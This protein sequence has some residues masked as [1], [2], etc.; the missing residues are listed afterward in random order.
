MSPQVVHGR[1]GDVRI[2]AHRHRSGLPT[3]AAVRA[4]RVVVRDARPARA[5]APRP[6][7]LRKRYHAR[8][9]AG[10]ARAATPRVRGI[11]T[12]DRAQKR[13]EEPFRE[14]LAPVRAETAVRTATVHRVEAPPD[15]H[16]D[17][18]GGHLPLLQPRPLE[19]EHLL[20]DRGRH[21]RARQHL[22]RMDGVLGLLLEHFHE[23]DAVRGD[24]QQRRDV[25]QVDLPR[26][27]LDRVRPEQRPAG[28]AFDAPRH[29]VRDG[30]DDDGDEQP[31]VS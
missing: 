27:R 3:K 12:H 13:P 17:G 24:A 15:A 21:D 4:V 31:Y 23:D 18:A 1:H 7:Q 25:V 19:L 8:G 6:A 16:R 28:L 20:R 2:G 29:F 26:P 9:T 22:V 10:P 11:V 14:R 5:E 30:R